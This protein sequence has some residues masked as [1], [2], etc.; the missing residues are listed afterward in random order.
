MERGGGGKKRNV[1][2]FVVN[3]F[4][5]FPFPFGF[6]VFSPLTNNNEPPSGMI[7]LE[8]RDE[9]LDKAHGG[10]VRV[11]K[12]G[13]RG[14]PAGIVSLSSRDSGASQKRKKKDKRKKGTHT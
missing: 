7:V 3:I 12:D 8:K 14:R 13:R 10:G 4:V 11:A 5:L 1:I 2:F 6:L 9:R